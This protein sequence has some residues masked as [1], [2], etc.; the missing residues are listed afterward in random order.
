M[1]EPF[2]ELI[3]TD[4]V[5]GAFDFESDKDIESFFIEYQTRN[6]KYGLIR[7][8]CEDF[9]NAFYGHVRSVQVRRA[10]FA[11]AGIGMMIYGLYKNKI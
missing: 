10:V 5:L 11:V 9:A 8:N 4:D 3:E 1:C 2:S 6:G 7:N